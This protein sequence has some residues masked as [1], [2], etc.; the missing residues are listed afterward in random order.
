MTRE[1]KRSVRKALKSNV[2]RELS[3][4]EV[5][6]MIKRL[7]RMAGL[8]RVYDWMFQDVARGLRFK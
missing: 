2:T 4:E 8:G 1:E 3:D 6:R 7:E 5:D